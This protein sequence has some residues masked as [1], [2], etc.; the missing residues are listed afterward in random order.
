MVDENKNPWQSIK[1]E[2]KYDN[3]WIKVIENDIINPSGNKGIYGVVSFKNLA[4]GIVPLDENYNTWIVGQYRYPLNKYSWEIPEGGGP[5]NIPPLESAKRELMEEVG[6]KAETWINIHEF[7]TSNSC[8][9]EHS[10]IY[11]AKGLSEHEA[12]PEES[13]QLTIKKIPFDELYQMVIDNKIMDSLTIIA[14]FK[15]KYLIDKGEI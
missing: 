1:S 12:T 10:I 6:L 14:V 7:N 9:D 2:V 15:T 3:P 11:V 8:T 4:I 13:E 5:L